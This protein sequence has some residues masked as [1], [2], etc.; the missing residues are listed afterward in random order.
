MNRP[1]LD[2]SQIARQSLLCEVRAGEVRPLII[3]VL[4]PRKFFVPMDATEAT[5]I[6]SD[7]QIDEFFPANL[8]RVIVSHTR[9]EPMMGVLRRLDN[10]PQLTRSLGYRNRGGTL[11]AAGL[12]FANG[13]TWAHI[14]VETCKS[15]D[16]DS[17]DFLSKV[18]LLA[19][20]GHGD[21]RIVM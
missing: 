13:A 10:G 14:I 5:S 18:E 8:L 12:L 19:L 6:A 9:P 3:D 17:G 21:P 1:E 16:L 20:S 11:D 7:T 2:I 4:E 15:S